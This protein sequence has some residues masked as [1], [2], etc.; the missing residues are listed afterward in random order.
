MSR[1]FRRH[2]KDNSMKKKEKKKREVLELLSFALFGDKIN[3]A[4]KG[5]YVLL[6]FALFG[7]LD[8]HSEVNPN[9][10]FQRKK[11]K[12][13]TFRFY[14]RIPY[15]FYFT[16]SITREISWIFPLFSHCDNKSHFLVSLHFFPKEKKKSPHNP[17]LWRAP[18]PE[19]LFR[20]MSPFALPRL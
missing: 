14:M 9:S 18:T 5:T 6:C 3:I 12:K 2:H 13:K 11:V 10:D 1:K 19:K 8:K 16:F 15:N 20:T 17:P 4:N 7:L